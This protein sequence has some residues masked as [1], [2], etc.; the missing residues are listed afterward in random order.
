[1]PRSDDDA[2][3]WEGDDDPTLEVGA[4]AAEPAVADPVTERAASEPAPAD[5]E[6]A[7]PIADVPER[8]APAAETLDATGGQGEP[9]GD[10]E[11]RGLGDAGLVVVGVIGGV[12]LLWTVGWV[13]GA[14]RLRD[15]I[16]VQTGAVADAMFH[17]SM[18]LAILAP[19]IWFGGSWYLTRRRPTWVRIV[20]LVLGVIVLVPWPFVMVGVIGR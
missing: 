11:R 9:V 6:P 2:L 7:D 10:P 19:A 1:M 3:S 17:G 18:V 16:Q 5:P 14:L 20:A 12:Y 13:L 15:W 8:P 4:D